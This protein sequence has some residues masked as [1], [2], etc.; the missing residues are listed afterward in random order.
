MSW[1]C[2]KDPFGDPY[3]IRDLPYFGMAEGQANPNLL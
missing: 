3:G 2:G 1:I